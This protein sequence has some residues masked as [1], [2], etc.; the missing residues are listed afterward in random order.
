MTPRKAPSLWLTLA[1]SLPMQPAYARVKIWRHLQAAGAVSIGKNA[2]YIL[3]ADDGLLER[4]Q[5][6]LTEAR[7]VGGDGVILEARL[8]AGHTD[9]SV[10]AL[11]REQRDAEFAGLA[12]EIGAW[13]SALK[14]DDTGPG[15]GDARAHLTRLAERARSI[16][17]RDFFPS[18]AGSGVQALLRAAERASARRA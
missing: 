15:S 4:F 16:A 10:R 13:L 2:L 6:V 3:P 9:D 14:Q 17:A 11:F 7:N 18:G 1:F 12:E 8:I 5:W